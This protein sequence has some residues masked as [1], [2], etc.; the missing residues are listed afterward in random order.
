VLLRLPFVAAPLSPDEGGFLVLARQ[1]HAAGPGGS[2]Y[3]RYWVD[4]P[5][6]LVATF[7][8]ADALG[9][10]TALRLIG[11]LASAIT[12]VAVGATVNRLSGPRPAAWASAGGVWAA[13]R[14]ERRRRERRRRAA[15][16]AVRRRGRRGGGRSPHHSRAVARPLGVGGSRVPVPLPRFW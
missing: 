4:R 13:G 11:A 14:S 15:R 5:P 9:G 8:L 2:L 1:W 3:G 10:L 16:G 6:L 7:Q 12:V